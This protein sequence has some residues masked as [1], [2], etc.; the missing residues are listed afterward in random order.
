MSPERPDYSGVNVDP[1][2]TVGGQAVIEGVM[3]RAPGAWSVAVRQPDASIVARREDLGRL[4]E[5]NRAARVPLIR[6]I[7][8]LW[9]SLSLGFRALSWSAEKASGE[10][11]EPLTKGQIGWTMV[12]ALVVFA[13][14]F[15]L[16]P[17][18]A[19][20]VVAGESGIL[21]NVVEGVIRLVMFVG[22]IWVIGRSAEIGRVF[23]YHGA[24][25]M[26]IHAF[27]AGEPLSIESVRRFPP[28]HPRCGT[29]FLLIVVLGSIILFSF[30]GQPGWAFLVAS[31]LL[32]I[33][34]I[35]GLAYELLR[36]SGTRN[37]GGLAR[38]LATPGIWLQ[39]LTTR[40]P[41]ESQIE[42]AISSLIVA[43]D[44]EMVEDVRRRGGLPT[45]AL[46]ARLAVMG[47]PP[48]GGE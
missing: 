10:E 43:L 17:A 31:R 3:M 13:G 1:A 30:F 25:H 8:V 24:E 5:R 16:L 36:W 7:L 15:I 2:K 26:S 29:S 46:D 20:G 6:G 37:T 14:L 22:Y 44:D 47:T 42:V 48:V 23:E 28:E 9:E 12:I 21:F 45:S 34:I 40:V 19:A 32:G 38:I 39:K 41:D 35:A 33:P 27:E 4:T 11:E 18:L